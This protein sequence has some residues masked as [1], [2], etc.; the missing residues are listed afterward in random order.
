MIYFVI[1]T[2]QLGKYLV[3]F[4]NGP[5]L[6]GTVLLEFF[7]ENIPYW[8]LTENAINITPKIGRIL[9]GPFVEHLTLTILFRL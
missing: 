4:R 9:K 3:P 2:K 8:I 6:S 7:S 5:D 1:S